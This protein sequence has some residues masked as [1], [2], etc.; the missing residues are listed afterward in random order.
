MTTRAGGWPPTSAK[1][2]Q[3][4]DALAHMTAARS[5]QIRPA[6]QVSQSGRGAHV[7]ICFAQATSAS[8]ARRP[9]L[10][11]AEGR[12]RERLNTQIRRRI[13]VV[14]FLGLVARRARS[15]S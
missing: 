7:W 15:R 5:H 12:T 11:A 4:L 6:L 10:G 8:V 2:Q 14:G 3:L 9:V 13:D 1:K